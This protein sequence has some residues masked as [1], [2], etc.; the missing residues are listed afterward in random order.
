VPADAPESSRES[1]TT[2]QSFGCSATPFG[3]RNPRR[4]W[5][6]ALWIASATLSE[7]LAWVRMLL[8]CRMPVRFSPV[9]HR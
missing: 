1:R 8:V 2:S 5:V 4:I 7:P 3:S 9:R 6:I